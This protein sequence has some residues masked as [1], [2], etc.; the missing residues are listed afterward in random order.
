MNLSLERSYPK[1]ADK[2]R[3]T[4]GYDKTCDIY[5]KK[6]VIFKEKSDDDL[7]ND[8][9]QVKDCVSTVLVKVNIAGL[10]PNFIAIRSTNR[11][12]W[13]VVSPTRASDFNQML[14]YFKPFLC[15]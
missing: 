6:S 9:N 2:I 8:D 13:L 12:V 11:G 10:A 15:F 4:S 3:L 1:P 5:E 7:V 14:L